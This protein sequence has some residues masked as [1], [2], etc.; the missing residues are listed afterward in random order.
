MPFQKIVMPTMKEL[1]VRQMESMILSGELSAGEQLPNERELAAQ[2]NLSR[3]VV[4]SGIQELANNGFV[5][6]LPRKGT[7]V[8]DF[9][10]QGNLGTL[11]SIFHHS[12]GQFDRSMLIALMEYRSINEQK[13]ARLA[14]E[15]RTDEDLKRMLEL[16]EQLEACSCPEECAEVSTQFHRAIFIATQNQIYPLMYNSFQE[17][18]TAVTRILFRHIPLPQVCTAMR[19]VAEA[20]ANQ[21]AQQAEKCMTEHTVRCTEILLQQ[22][23]F[24][25]A[26]LETIK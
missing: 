12:G 22:Y 5:C 7:F 17:M 11:T 18:S 3:T 24:G 9:L 25:S 23:P 15:R 16:L 13:C 10:R 21:D 4:N 2:M 26:G 20:I 14:A 19:S 1:F 8:N 6:I